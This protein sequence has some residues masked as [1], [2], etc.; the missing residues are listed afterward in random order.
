[1]FFCCSSIG[2]RDLKVQIIKPQGEE[3]S[4]V[5]R[6]NESVAV[7][8]GIPHMSGSIAS[9]VAS[10]Y[11]D[12]VM[13]G[14]GYR[15]NPLVVET[16]LQERTKIQ[17][18]ISDG[19]LEIVVNDL[20]E[21]QG[22]LKAETIG[23]QMDV[24]FIPAEGFEGQARFSVQIYKNGVLYDEKH[25]QINVMDKS[26]TVE[27]D[28]AIFSHTQNSQLSLQRLKSSIALI[29]P[30]YEVSKIAT[31][32]IKANQSTEK[33]IQS[34]VEETL[35]SNS[36][37]DQEVGQILSQVILNEED[38]MLRARL[39]NS[40]AIQ[41]LLEDIHI[42]EVADYLMNENEDLAL[43]FVE[44]IKQIKYK[45]NNNELSEQE[46]KKRS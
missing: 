19:M 38:E 11:G 34:I 7:S 32:L 14:E 28:K 10:A 17:S 12:R 16:P 44:H 26:Q 1:M 25:Y 42:S 43:E 27:A 13:Q 3:A 33:V 6:I 37:T 24:D 30:T 29:E 9:E 41:P 18:V 8:A 15:L 23:Q 22:I 2:L 46:Q 5:A 39:I 21:A 35:A 40:I 31:G 4:R 20:D 36:C 45:E